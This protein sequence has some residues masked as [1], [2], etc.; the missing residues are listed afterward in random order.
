MTPKPSHLLLFL[1]WTLAQTAVAQVDRKATDA[2]KNLLTNLNRLAANG[3]L[4]G[5]QD[6]PAYGLN[7]DSTRWV[8]EAGRSDVRAVAGEYP[9]VVGWD[10][11]RIE[12]D[13]ARNLDGVPF[14]RMRGWMRE[15]HGRGGVNT[16]SWH[17]NNPT[18]PAKSSWDK[19]D[20]TIRKVLTNRK[21]RKQYRAWLGKVAAFL[22]SV[23][24]PEGEP[25]PVI[26]RPLHEHTGSWF[27][28]GK[29]HCSPEEY[30][31]FWKLT[32]D[33]LR[34]KGKV[35]HVLYA[36]STDV[37]ASPAD[38]LERYP[39]DDYA[40]LLGFD[41]YHRNATPKGDSAF[42]ANTRRMLRDLTQLAA[43]R[44][45]PVAITETGIDRVKEPA[46]WTR[47]LLPIVQGFNLS[48]V[49]VWR[50]GRPDH[51][52][53]PFPGQKSAG[54]F[55]QFVRHPRVMLEKKVAAEKMYDSP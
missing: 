1:A 3:V 8:G 51:Y 49:L 31:K 2:T 12:F 28:W 27:W 40:D 10:L 37:F 42:I 16:V 35:H 15:V 9:A 46:W 32:V 54:D 11:G 55:S 26:F 5:H 17:L 52:Y 25:I 4:F 38:Y 53:A 41:T 24:T 48:Y 23:K 43:E 21:N 22:N 44:G 13:S 29:A 6:D 36:Y 18:D 39:G 50:N 45:K 30:T 47:V 14:D 7:P 19:A 34:K 20:S 33:F